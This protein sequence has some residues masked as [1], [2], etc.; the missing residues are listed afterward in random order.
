MAGNLIEQMNILKGLSDEALNYEMS[1]PSGAAPPYLVLTEVQRRKDMRSRYEGEAARQKRRTTVAEDLVMPMGGQMRP[2]GGMP[3]GGIAAAEVPGFA[4]G[5]LID[6]GALE[7]RYNDRLNSLGAGRDRARALALI[8]AGAGIMGGGHSNTLQNIG[9]GA[10]AGIN[11]YSDAIKTVDSEELNLLRGLTD[12]GQLQQSLAAADEDRALR[13][14]E[15][16]ISRDRL[17]T[18][19]KPANVLEFEYWQSLD[20]ESKKEYERLNPAFNPNA[21]TEIERRRDDYDKIYADA[22]KMFPISEWDDETTAAEK[23]RKAQAAA[24]QRI[25]AR[26]GKLAAEEWA[27]NQGLALGDIVVNSAAPVLD[28]KDP[29]GLGL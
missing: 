27:R 19:K 18:D 2:V 26:D 9:L 29:L 11:A 15:I 8:A 10:Q 20:P 7:T 5:G 28:Q 13:R 6:Y 4:S 16:G 22:Q 3:T 14:E 17:T 21:V 23:V 24:Y 1:A 12:I 25:A